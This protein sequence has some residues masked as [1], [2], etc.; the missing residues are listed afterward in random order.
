M[1]F[2]RGRQEHGF[3]DGLSPLQAYKPLNNGNP[4][5]QRCSGAFACEDLPI[6]YNIRILIYCIPQP[7]LE[8]GVRGSVPSLKDTRVCEHIW[9]CAYSSRKL[10]LIVKFSDQVFDTQIRIQVVGAAD[11]R[12]ARACQ[13][14]RRVLHQWQCQE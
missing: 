5:I 11:R 2:L 12:E 3:F 14:Y 7:V 13:N 9:G 10:S 1:A 8:C 4:K 6:H